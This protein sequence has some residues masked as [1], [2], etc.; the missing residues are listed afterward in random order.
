MATSS[1]PN[2]SPI[3]TIERISVRIPGPASGPASVRS[4]GA[5][6]H[7]RDGSD[8]ANAV[9]PVTVRKADVTTAADGLAAATIRA[10]RS[11]P[12]MKYASVRTDSSA[13]AVSRRSESG[14][15]KA[16]SARIDADI[17]GSAPPPTAAS[18][19]SQAMATC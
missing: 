9:V 7:L 12:A 3:G 1:V 5:A 15:R 13:K 2:A 10:V 14:I 8:V 6:R 17:G 11:G 16:H 18:T 4:D 19:V